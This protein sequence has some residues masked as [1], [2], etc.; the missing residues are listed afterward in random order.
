MV[1]TFIPG[2]QI[3]GE[4]FAKRTFIMTKRPE[5]FSSFERKVTEMTA[6]DLY[7]YIL[8]L[9]RDGYDSR[10]YWAELQGE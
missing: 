4:N 1:Q 2:G 5:E 3:I 6:K 7:R 8:R 10:P 9:E